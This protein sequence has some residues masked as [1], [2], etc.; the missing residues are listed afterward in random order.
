MALMPKASKSHK[1][2]FTISPEAIIS[3]RQLAS[4]QKVL[5]T[6]AALLITIIG[7]RYIAAA[8]IAPILLAAFFAVLMNP[9]FQWFRRRGFSSGVSVVLMLLTII[10]VLLVLGVFISWSFALIGAQLDEHLTAV[11]ESLA[12]LSSQLSIDNSTNAW[13]TQLNPEVVLGVVAGLAN[14]L[15]SI[16]LYLVLMPLLSLLL[17]LQLDSVPKKVIDELFSDNA[18]L[19]SLRKFS[20]TVT[21]YVS[22][23][24]KVNLI[25]GLLFSIALLLLGIPYPFIWG[26]L[27]VFLSFI[28]YVGI[29]IA[30]IAPVMLSLSIGGSAMLLAT[31]L[32][33]AGIDIFVE[34]LVAPYIMGKT[35]KISTASIV[36]G[37]IFW[38]WIFG[39]I[40][41][42]LS[43]PLTVLLKAILANYKETTWIAALMEGNY[44]AP[45]VKEKVKPRSLAKTKRF[46]TKV[47]ASILK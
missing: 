3:S 31:V 7:L 16:A 23:R 38:M 47:T 13:I 40:G 28:P 27:A 8:L 43:V 1:K 12:A 29:V 18:N 46:F 20:S 19:A 30:S 15:G 39:P 44:E 26:L 22:G 37:L 5:I 17:L 25:A 45:S 24:L 10:C 9:L 21:R 36:I 4:I 11:R 42:I 34:N 6:F 32:A 14:N 35:N 41:A 33:I 2:T